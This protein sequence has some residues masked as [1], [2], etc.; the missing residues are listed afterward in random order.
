MEVRGSRK[1]GLS[2]MGVPEGTLLGLLGNVGPLQSLHTCSAIR[3]TLVG[4]S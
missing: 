4:R 3:L 2:G 1:W